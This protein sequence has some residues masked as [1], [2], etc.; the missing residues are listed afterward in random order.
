[1]PGTRRAPAPDAE[2]A[3]NA[4][5]ARERLRTELR[6]AVAELRSQHHFRA[7]LRACAALPRYS[8]T[9]VMLIAAQARHRGLEPGEAASVPTWARLGYRVRAG[10]RG[11]MIRRPV[12]VRDQHRDP[13]ERVPARERRP[14]NFRPGYVFCRTQVE[15]HP[16]RT[17]LP[18]ELPDPPIPGR[19]FRRELARLE[20]ALTADGWIITREAL[21]PGTGGLCNPDRRAIVIA[22][23]LESDAQLRVLVHEAA[24]GEGVVARTHGR[25]RAECIVEAATFIVC[26]RIGLDVTASSVPY[27]AGWD[28]ADPGTIERDAADINRVALAIEHRLRDQPRAA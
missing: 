13:D 23:E 1:M 25:A 21:P 24:H 2:R 11:L 14:V 5:I 9:N 12:K 19:A 17:Q 3:A 15:P 28:A 7:W 20:H 8:P 4:A 22:G 26:A 10:E 18:L 16:G 27:I 6:D